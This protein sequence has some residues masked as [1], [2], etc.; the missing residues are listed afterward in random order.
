MFS[1]VYELSWCFYALDSKCR[2]EFQIVILR[3]RFSLCFYQLHFSGDDAPFFLSR[4]QPVQ[5]VFVWHGLSC[6][7]VVIEEFDTAFTNKY[8][9]SVDDNSSNVNLP[10]LVV[11]ASLVARSL[12]LLASDNNLRFDSPIFESIQVLPRF[13]CS[14]TSSLCYFHVYLLYSPNLCSGVCSEI[15]PKRLWCCQHSFNLH[16]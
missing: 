2:S 12:V 8:Y 1:P 3:V 16:L 14:W 5:N 13:F 4:F 7:G 6:V 15:P 10:S 9:N 11:A